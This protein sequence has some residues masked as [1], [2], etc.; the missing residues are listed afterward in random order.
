MDQ[1][2]SGMPEV[3]EAIYRKK[4]FFGY[5]PAGSDTIDTVTG[6]A[7]FISNLML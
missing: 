2:K 5:A 4:E 7:L 6:T 1:G 3:I